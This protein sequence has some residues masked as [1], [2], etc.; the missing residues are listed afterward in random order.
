[1]VENTLKNFHKIFVFTVVSICF[2]LVFLCACAENISQDDVVAKKEAVINFCKD[3]YFT[4]VPIE[5]IEYVG[6]S[7]EFQM[8]EFFVEYNAK[9]YYK[10]LD[11]YDNTDEIETF[12]ETFF[13]NN[14]QGSFVVYTREL[15]TQ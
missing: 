12:K 7:K 11:I 3:R 8:H 1:M 9:Y 2:V 6:F 14:E 15:L 5:C 4:H 13:V 10:D